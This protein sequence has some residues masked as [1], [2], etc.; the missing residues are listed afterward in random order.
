MDQNQLAGNGRAQPLPPAS[1]G[2]A[3]SMKRW[4]C[5]GRRCLSSSPNEVAQA[6]RLLMKDLPAA[7]PG[8]RP[9]QVLLLGQCTTNYLPPVLTAWAWAE[10][11]HVSRA[12][13]RV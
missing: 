10:G 6:G 12:R 9:V 4:R 11:L 1:Q 7:L 2:R 5:S 8:G 13:R 3:V